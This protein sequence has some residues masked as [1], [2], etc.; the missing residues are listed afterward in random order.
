MGHRA[1]LLFSGPD[2]PRQ[3]ECERRN[4]IRPLQLCSQRIGMEPSPWSVAVHISAQPARS[5]LLR[6]CIPDAGN[7]KSIARELTAIELDQR[8]RCE[9]ARAA[10]PRELL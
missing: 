1:V 8:P 2:S 6:S 7:G 10:G 9:A 5:R 3:M 4:S